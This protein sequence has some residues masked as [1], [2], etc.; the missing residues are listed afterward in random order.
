MRLTVSVILAS[1]LLLCVACKKSE[2]VGGTKPQTS[3][4]L[5]A[6]GDTYGQFAPDD[7]WA[8]DPNFAY[9]GSENEWTR[10]QFSA[11]SAELLYKR[12]GQRQLLEILDG[13]LDEATF[14]AEFR[15]EEDPT[16]A[17]SWFILTVVYSVKNDVPKAMESMK[18]ALENGMSITR[19]QAGPRG[20]LKPLTES[21]SFKKL[22]ESMGTHLIHGPMLGAVG[23]DRASFW[24]RTSGEDLVEIRCYDASGSSVAS[25]S[26]STRAA[27]DYSVVVTVAGLRPASDYRY[28][29]LINGTVVTSNSRSSFKTYPRKGVS[30]SYRIGVGGCAGYTPRYEYMWTTLA[31]HK[32]D[33]MLM[34]GDNVYIDIPELPGPFH[35]YTYYRR[36][37]RPEFRN[38]VKSTAMYAIW[39]DHDSATDDVWMGPYRDKPDWKQPLL[40]H[41]QRNWVNPEMGD[42][43]W[44]GCWF[45]FSLGDVDIFMLDG[46]TYRTNP[47]KEE[48]TMLGPVQKSWLMKGLKSS[49]ATFK[50]IGSPVAWASEAKPDS[51]DTWNGFINEREEIFQFLSD[52]HIEGVLLLSGDRHRTDFW[53]NERKGDYP[54]Y[55]LMSCRLTNIHTH[56][57]MPDAIFGY[58]EKP[59]F[60]ILNIDTELPDPEVRF[61]AVNIDNEVVH[62]YTVRLS[63][64]S[65]PKR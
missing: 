2:K 47:F 20:L 14:L 33:A 52:N 43:D 56:D 19:F 6:I 62:S 50:I 36:Q 4:E 31:S 37:S 44:P 24:L 54:L 65:Y 57:L 12:R 21:E 30:G 25:A 53:K 58:N 11:V 5:K 51:N 42:P 34:L 18:K 63:E 23:S 60:G 40:A 32:F 16:D 26:G 45:S 38:L 59:S 55:E 1:L 46:R 22:V 61:D 41:F 8:E 17:E 35:D 10:R 49:T 48:K 39:D 9:Y 15:L 28:E 13:N 27:A 29:V 3:E 7:A 64:I